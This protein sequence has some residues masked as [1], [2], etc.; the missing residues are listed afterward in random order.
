MVNH[1]NVFESR[2]RTGFVFCHVVHEENGTRSEII[3]TAACMK[4]VYESLNDRSTSRSKHESTVLVHR[5]HDLLTEVVKD[6]FLS[7]AGNIRLSR[8]F[9]PTDGE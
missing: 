1:V 4:C 8:P 3:L 6:N 7:N 9:F 5:G 2:G